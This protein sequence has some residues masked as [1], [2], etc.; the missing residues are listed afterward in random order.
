LTFT[1][2][3]TSTS[4][5]GAYP[6]T[7]GGLTSTNY[8]ITFVA[9]V[10]D[11]TTAFRI[12]GFDSPV[13]MTVVG[14]ERNYNSVKNGQTVPLKFRV[15]NLDGT[16]VSSLVGLSA[17]S[18]TVTCATGDIDPTLLP[19]VSTADT[20][21]RRTGDRFHFNWAVPKGAGR[22]YQIVVQTI[23]GSTTMVGS[24]RGS[25]VVEA[26]FKTK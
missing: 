11:I 16:E 17:W 13:D 26:Y 21:L 6:V 20:G 10:L 15:F 14:D 24:L 12:V 1:T 5:I 18:R 8:T 23:D 7:P 4:L 19:I 25:P 22:C 2:T 9:G 3:A